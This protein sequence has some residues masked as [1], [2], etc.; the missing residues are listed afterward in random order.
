MTPECPLGTFQ[1]VTDSMLSKG[2]DTD[3]YWYQWKHSGKPYNHFTSPVMVDLNGDLMLDYFSSLHGAS[4]DEETNEMMELAIMRVQ[5]DQSSTRDS[6]YFLDPLQNRIILEDIAEDGYQFLDKHSDLVVD[7]DNDGIL[8]IYV[9]SGGGGGRPMNY[10]QGRDNLVFFG[11]HVNDNSTEGSP[12]IVFKGGRMRA[13]ESNIHMRMGRGRFTYLLD[14][15]GDGLLDIFT[16]NARRKD[17]DLAPGILHINEG[18]RTWRLEDSMSEFSNAMILTDADGDGIAEEFMVTRDFCFPNRDDPEADPEFGPFPD[19]INTFCSTRP[20]GTTAVYKFNHTSNSMEEISQSY[21]NIQ[22]ASSYQPECC[23]HGLRSGQFDCSVVSLA[24]ADFDS[25]GKTDHVFLYGRKMQFYFSSDRPK[26]VLPIGNQYIGLT[27]DLPTTCMFGKGIRLVDL[28]NSG[29]LDIIVMCQNV[30][31]VLLYTQGNT[32]DSWTLDNGCNGYGSLGDLAFSAFEWQTEDILDACENRDAWKKLGPICDEYVINGKKDIPITQGMTLADINNDG[33]TDAIVATKLGYQRFFLN[34]PSTTASSNKFLSFRLIGDGNE[35]NKYGIGVTLK[36]RC[37]E[38][39]LRIRQFR[40]ISSYQHSTDQNG[41]IDEKITFG[42]GKNM[43]PI[44]LIARWPNGRKQKLNLRRFD[45]SSYKIIDV[46][47]PPQNNARKLKIFQLRQPSK[48]GQKLCLS[49][50]QG[51]E[52]RKI[53]FEQCVSSAYQNFWFDN[54]G[55][56]RNDVLPN[57]C[58]TA[59]YKSNS[60]RMIKCNKKISK[61]NSWHLTPD[62]SFLRSSGSNLV[63]GIDS[64]S[65]STTGGIATLVD[66]DMSKHGQKIYMRKAK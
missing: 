47:Y 48:S 50:G 63:I 27:I 34:M 16:S 7:L 22:A 54:A 36:L 35:V 62:S 3:A 32:K 52:W 49:I 53:K 64:S 56:L 1:D 55:R 5:P 6:S 13:L 29:K 21:V 39:K 20:V 28:D 14:V 65:N 59:R 37:K 45:F 44:K 41:S 58:V 33:F 11:E 60:I 25:D 10:P 9:A 46:R 8:D 23:P 15:N 24:S 19:N 66:L 43:S 38:G 12:N 4:M 26:G 40:E 18:N 17:N 30:G 51:H 61:R 57:F 42:L 2:G 31:K